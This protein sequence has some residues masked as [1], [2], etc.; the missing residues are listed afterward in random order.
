VRNI[1][2]VL[3]VRV[4]QYPKRSETA[5]ERITEKSRKERVMAGNTALTDLLL[6]RQPNPSRQAPPNSEEKQTTGAGAK[7]AIASPS[8][9]QPTLESIDAKSTATIPATNRS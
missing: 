8:N 7:R 3:L 5:P 4:K 9:I 1:V 6:V 2:L